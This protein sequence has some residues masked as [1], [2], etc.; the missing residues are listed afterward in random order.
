MASLCEMRPAPPSCETLRM[1]LQYR[2]ARGLNTYEGT[3]AG[4]MRMATRI[5][6]LKEILLHLR[7]EGGRDRP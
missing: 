2:G 6:E 7:R 3:A 1:A 4:Y 5:K